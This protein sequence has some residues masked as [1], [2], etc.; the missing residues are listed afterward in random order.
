MFEPSPSR[1]L[2]FGGRGI[3]PAGRRIALRFEGERLL[4]LEGESVAAALT[5]AGILHLRTTAEGTPRGLFCGMG[6]CHDCLV[7]I[8]GEPNRR[9]C[10]MKVRDGMEV[11]RQAH[12]APMS[13]APEPPGPSPAPE[14]RDLVVVGAGPAGLAAALAAAR[15]GLAAL[16]VD[17]R[18]QPGG[19]YYKPLAE[20]HRFASGRAADRQFR[21]GLTL[22][23]RVRAAGVEILSGAEVWGA[24]P[25]ADGDAPPGLRLGILQDGIARDLYARRLVLATGAY[26]R[27]WPVPGWTLPGVM[28]TGA[29]Q[30]LARA[31]RVAPG[32]RILLAGNGPLNLQVA[33]ELLRGGAEVVAVAEAAAA[34]G[35][36]RLRDLMGLLAC[37]PDLFRDGLAMRA[38]LARRGVPLM[39]RHVV[40]RVEGEDRVTR[41][42]LAA[43]DDEGRVVP[44]GERSFEIDALCLGYGF[45]PSGELARVLGCRHVPAAGGGLVV[46]RD[47]DGRTSRPDVLVA[48]DGGGIGGARVALAQGTLAGLAAARALC[49]TLPAEAEDEIVGARRDLARARRFQDHLWRLFASPLAAPPAIADDTSVCRCE[50]VLAG[51]LRAAVAAGAGEIGSLK[52]ATRAGM[53]RCQGRYCG[54]WLAEACAGA[55]V[56]RLDAFAF[57]APRLP[58]KPT[59]LASIAREQPDPEGFAEALPPASPQ[60]PI[61]EVNREHRAEVAVI[62]AGILGAFAALELAR[63]GMDVIVLEQG[64]PNGQA[65]GSNAGSLHVQLLTYDLKRGADHPYAGNAL[66]TLPLQR[67]SAA[68]WPEIAAALGEDL[69]IE[70]TGGLALAED[71]EALAHLRR[72]AELERAHGIEVEILGAEELHALAPRVSPRMIGAALCPA[73]GKINPMLATPA[74]LR[75]AEAAGARIL[76]YCEVRGIARAGGTFVIASSRGQVRTGR[77]LNAAGAWAPRIA[78]MLGIELPVHAAPLQMIVTEPAPRLAHQLLAHARRRLTLKQVRTGHLVIGG[79]WPAAVDE[80]TGLPRVDPDSLAGNLWVAARVLPAAGG[81]H[82]LRSW[83]AMNVYLD[84]APILG[85]TPGLPSFHNLLTMNGVTL[86]PLLGRAAADMLRTGEVPEAFAPFTLAR[87]GA[88]A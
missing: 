77:V 6:V 30:T 15:A 55:S 31:F 70:I 68:M 9:A 7:G 81:L 32:R 72:K 5:A 27:P 43:I 3:A 74:V 65:S 48:G 71:E 1:R 54:S 34:P 82:V 20:S 11:T 57:M 36:A 38:L 84:G 8:D 79:G 46:E 56:R 63:A 85:P 18:P 16:V 88:A 35:M 73:E 53:G 61:E 26:E 87:F 60:P 40:V 59:P 52:R 28:T 67:D 33:C 37:A 39:H 4:A 83:A 19:Q 66:R 25:P 12:V 17:E 78:A 86:A 64:A 24:F 2:R 10:Q 13:P 47:E 41:A 58:I 42:V 75:A 76:P 51:R 21:D 49:D 14:A 50:S 69:E 62:G 80:S 44:G 22:L 45:L 29:A 23:E